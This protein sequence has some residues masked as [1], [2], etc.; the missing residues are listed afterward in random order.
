MRIKFDSNGNRTLLIDRSDLAG[1]RGF[2]IQ[3]LGNLP[4]THRFGVGEY[5]DAEVRAYL[6]ECGTPRQRK[7]YGIA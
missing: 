5:T 2:S 7:L 6:T 1:A 4:E 3:T